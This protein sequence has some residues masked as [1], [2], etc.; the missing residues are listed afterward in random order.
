M[1]RLVAVA[2]LAVRDLW[3]SY[4]LLILVAGLLLAALPAALQA[5]LP[6]QAAPLTGR[7]EPF[8]IGLAIALALTAGVAAWSL[9]AER[10]GGTAGW[11]VTRAV[12]RSVVVMGWFAA[13]AAVL[14]I[15]LLPSAVLVW[16]T[17]P[18]TEAQAIDP[19]GYAAAVA[20]AWAAGLA[21]VALGL[22]LGTMLEP[23]FAGAVALLAGGALLLPAV[24][25]PLPELAMPP[26][27]AAALV[28]LGDLQAA[29]RPIA[30]SLQSGGASLAAAGAI[31]VL[32]AATMQR[33][34]L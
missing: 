8:A 3:V 34:D 28:V 15:G 11:L 6:Q 32:A 18:L 29:A 17:L 13:F 23:L 20:A 24:L 4:R 2:G 5:A 10:S 9:S 25:G 26:A 22:L 12:P 27:P 7:L 30:D 21:A 19:A 1:S 33:A 16:L 14:L 31:L